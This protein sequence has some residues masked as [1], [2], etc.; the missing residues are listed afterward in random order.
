MLDGSG[1]QPTND[2]KADHRREEPQEP[3]LDDFDF[4]IA[5]NELKRR[6]PPG[7]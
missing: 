4:E 7:I 5:L 1:K 3:E 6:S 2:H